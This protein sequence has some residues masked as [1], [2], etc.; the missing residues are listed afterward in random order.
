MNAGQK[1]FYDFALQRVQPGKEAEITAIMTESFKR[2][3]EGTFSREYMGQV[4]P[5]MMALLRPECIGE[6]KKAAAHMGSQLK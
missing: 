4:M 5:K 3:D 6:L 2:Q 1:Q